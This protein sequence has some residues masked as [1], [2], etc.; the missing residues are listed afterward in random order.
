MWDSRGQDRLQQSV[1]GARS[2]ALN[3]GR[4]VRES[5][6]ASGS[7]FVRAE[8]EPPFLGGSARRNKCVL[9]VIFDPTDAKYPPDTSDF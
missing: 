6:R 9:L 4:R 2:I 7:W 1:R 3:E 5:D 8:P